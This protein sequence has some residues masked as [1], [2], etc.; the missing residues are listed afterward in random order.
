MGGKARAPLWSCSVQVPVRHPGDLV[1]EADGSVGLELSR[2]VSARVITV[3][4]ISV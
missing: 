4:I 3:G 1:K 2:K